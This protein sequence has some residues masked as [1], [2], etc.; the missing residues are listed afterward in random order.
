[1]TRLNWSNANLFVCTQRKHTNTEISDLNSSSSDLGR[2]MAP[3]VNQN[4]EFTRRCN[5]YLDS[6]WYGSPRQTGTVQ[7]EVLY[8][9]YWRSTGT[10]AS[11][12]IEA[13]KKTQSCTWRANWRKLLTQTVWLLRCKNG[14]GTGEIR[15]I[16]QSMRF[17][18][19]TAHWLN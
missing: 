5:L 19:P 2:P 9:T 12:V 13:L 17:F 15:K 11:L 6:R 4:V 3:Q 18:Y 8:V 16:P 7:S 1:M 14:D 10:F